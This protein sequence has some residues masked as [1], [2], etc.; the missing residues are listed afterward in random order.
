MHDQAS[1]DNGAELMRG[2]SMVVGNQDT[3][4]PEGAEGLVAGFV[5]AAMANGMSNIKTVEDAPGI[6]VWLLD[7][8]DVP[9][10]AI[11]MDELGN[12][13]MVRRDGWATVQY[14]ADEVS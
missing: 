4:I 1:T 11:A 14:F 13:A 3:R 8:S 7:G 12:W 5:E 9:A 2:P 10:L 6:G